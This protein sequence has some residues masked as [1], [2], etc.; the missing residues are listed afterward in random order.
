MAQ[1][2]VTTTV[3]T[4]GFHSV[5][6]LALSPQRM[7]ILGPQAERCRSLPPLISTISNW[8]TLY[9]GPRV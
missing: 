9:W 3:M 1:E 4:D 2:T 5:W 7:V 8:S 6:S